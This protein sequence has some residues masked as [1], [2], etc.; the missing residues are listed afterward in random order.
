MDTLNSLLLSQITS[1]LYFSVD[2]KRAFMQGAGLA[3]LSA[4]LLP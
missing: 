3:E 2:G 1:L 4:L